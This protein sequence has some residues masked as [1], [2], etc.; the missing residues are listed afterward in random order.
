VV[1]APA[2]R[3][4]TLPLFL[5]YPYMCSVGVT[6]LSP[7]LRLYVHKMTKQ[8]T[9]IPDG[10]WGGGRERVEI[11]V[12]LKNRDFLPLTTVECLQIRAAGFFIIASFQLPA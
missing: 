12:I 10:W 11:S 5:L 9:L 4:D 6:P 2:E 8:N 7:T 3:A 1:Y